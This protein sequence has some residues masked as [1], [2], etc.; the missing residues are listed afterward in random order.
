MSE[1]QN[2]KYMEVVDDVSNIN[3]ESYFPIYTGGSRVSYKNV[4][5]TNF[6]N[7]TFNFTIQ[8]P[9]LNTIV[10]RVIML[11]TNIKL[12]FTGSI[13]SGVTETSQ[14]INAGYDAFRAIPLASNMSNMSVTLGT[15]TN[16][17]NIK[18]LIQP[19]S[20]YNNN[21]LKVRGVQSMA[22]DCLDQTQ[23]YDDL[24]GTIR[25]PLGVFHNTSPMSGISGRGGFPYVI[26]NN[27]ATGAEIDA[28]ITEY[29][30]V[31]PF[32]SNNSCQEKGLVGLK[33]IEFIFN[34]QTNLNR[35]WSHSNKLTT[36]NSIEVKFSKPTLT[37]KF[38]SPS[39]TKPVP[40]LIYYPYY[41]VE[42]RPTNQNGGLLPGASMDVN[43]NTIELV[44]VPRRLYFFARIED[45]FLDI[46]RPD[47]YF[48]IEGISLTLENQSGLL[49]NATQQDLYRMSVENGCN[50][51]WAEWSGQ[52]TNFNLSGNPDEY[53]GAGSVLCIELGKDV[54]LVDRVP[55]SL[56]KFQVQAK[57]RVTNNTNYPFTTTNSMGQVTIIPTPF[58]LYMV[59]VQFGTF[60]I[61]NGNSMNMLGL[62][63]L[64]DILN[65]K[66]VNS[67]A[68]LDQQRITGTSF[69]GGNIFKNIGNFFRKKVVPVAKD[70]G[71]EL[72]HD[73]LPK[74]VR[75]SLGKIAKSFGLGY[76][77]I[78][79]MYNDSNQNIDNL[80]NKLEMK[81]YKRK[82][83]RKA[84]ARKKGG[85][86]LTRT[87][88]KKLLQRM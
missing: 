41:K 69:I 70:I 86:K 68:S 24:L 38:V 46:T 17:I 40:S 87:E 3:E 57:L 11:K 84:P 28:V 88:M 2:L 76:A 26:V 58:T 52:K 33:T 12:I 1:I 67:V 53:Y 34:F 85:A 49:S 47:S 13:N 15:I 45:K 82:A 83:R 43:T 50:M 63:S 29:L 19:L 60:V 75:S 54:G 7:S 37:V 56:G 14:L 65:S 42:R 62:P 44:S 32:L 74:F 59:D 51:S 79:K 8:V 71:N 10:D 27:N 78:E 48:S 55:G 72:I 9:S 5:T 73:A 64:V 20:R 36:I 23:N 4:T 81:G 66:Q 61:S 21:P 35:I 30:Y 25:N 18:D 31:S 80:I 6:S 22:P 77:E 39:I 16:S